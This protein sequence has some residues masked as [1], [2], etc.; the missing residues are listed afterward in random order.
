MSYQTSAVYGDA[1]YGN[2]VYNW[3]VAAISAVIGGIYSTV[4]AASRHTTTIADSD[5]ES[6]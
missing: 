5:T 2:A 1:V 6:S 3:V 4:I